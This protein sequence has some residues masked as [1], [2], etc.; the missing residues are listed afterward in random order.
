MN[1]YFHDID[2][3]LSEPETI[4]KLMRQGYTVLVKNIDGQTFDKKYTVIQGKLNNIK[5]VAVGRN[6]EIIA[7]QG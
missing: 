4:K 5:Q 3:K 7:L 1:K 6:G 2:R